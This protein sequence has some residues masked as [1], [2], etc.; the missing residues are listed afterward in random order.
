[1]KRPILLA[2][3]EGSAQGQMAS[4]LALSL[5]RTAR[6]IKLKSQPAASFASLFC[7]TWQ[8]HLYILNTGQR[9]ALHGGVRSDALHRI[10]CR[11]RNTEGRGT[12]SMLL[13]LL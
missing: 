4:A 11:P 1:V 7:G 13:I 3:P 2:M 9:L 10:V 5:M 12:L 8:R 6:A